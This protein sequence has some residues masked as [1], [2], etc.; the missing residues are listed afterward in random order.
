MP[1]KETL[2]QIKE[3]NKREIRRRTSDRITA[4]MIENIKEEA[5]RRRN[6]HCSS[7]D[8]NAET[9][10]VSDE[11]DCKPTKRNRR[12]TMVPDELNEEYANP[13]RPVNRNDNSICLHLLSFI[14]ILLIFNVLYLQ[15]YLLNNS[16][17]R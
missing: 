11:D 7:D 8:D 12:C 13:T 3:R 9:H 16:A 10:D 4:L 15:H 5:R 17:M 2:Q 1:P 6:M 14:I